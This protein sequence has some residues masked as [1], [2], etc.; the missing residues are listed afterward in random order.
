MAAI[1]IP[2]TT[3]ATDGIAV[4][5]TEATVG[6]EATAGIAI[7]VTAATGVATGAVIGIVIAVTTVVIAEGT[8]ASATETPGM[9]RTTIAESVTVTVTIETTV[10]RDGVDIRNTY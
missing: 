3:V 2:R 8:D 10:V 9:K 4:T 1:A 5:G 6:T 7:G